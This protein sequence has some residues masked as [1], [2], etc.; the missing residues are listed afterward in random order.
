[1]TSKYN[2]FPVNSRNLFTGGQKSYLKWS[3]K[4]NTPKDFSNAKHQPLPQRKKKFLKRN[5]AAAI[6]FLFQN[7]CHEPRGISFLQGGKRENSHLYIYLQQLILFVRHVHRIK[8]E[9]AHTHNALTDT[10]RTISN[11]EGKK[12]NQ[13]K[14]KDDGSLAALAKERNTLHTHARA[15]TEFIRS[16]R[17]SPFVRLSV[18]GQG[19]HPTSYPPPPP[20]FFFST[21]RHHPFPTLPSRPAT[22]KEERRVCAPWAG[23]RVG[24]G[25]WQGGVVGER[26][27]AAARLYKFITTTAGGDHRGGS[28]RFLPRAHSPQAREEGGVHRPVDEVSGGG[29]YL[30]R[31]GRNGSNK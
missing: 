9:H 6:F 25:W 27:R 12:K 11:D 13:Q 2:T 7:T 1:M 20:P 14:K 26:E 30:Q 19:D 10:H 15:H 5:H 4:K 22:G 16:T 29:G 3:F 31:P 18:P 17:A 28:G 24:G 21:E 23:G 8:L